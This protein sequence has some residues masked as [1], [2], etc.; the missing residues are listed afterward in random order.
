[1]HI[2]TILEHAHCHLHMVCLCTQCSFTCAQKKIN[3]A[4]Q[5]QSWVIIVKWLIC[6]E[7]LQPLLLLP[8][9]TSTVVSYL[10]FC[11]QAS[12]PCQKV[13]LLWSLYE[14]YSCCFAN[15]LHSCTVSIMVALKSFLLSV[16]SSLP[17]FENLDGININ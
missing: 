13:G 8:I 14:T 11:S 9:P 12:S 6:I 5:K 2:T 7:H 16:N 3:R 10:S 15:F 1:M 4:H 17:A